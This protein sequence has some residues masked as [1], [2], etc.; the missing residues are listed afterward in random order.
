MSKDFKIKN[1]ANQILIK[2]F[3][4]QSTSFHTNNISNTLS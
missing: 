2:K 1:N 4:Y 3:Q